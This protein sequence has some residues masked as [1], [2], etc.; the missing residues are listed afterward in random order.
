MV[1]WFGYFNMAL[2][3]NGCKLYI[4]AVQNG[5]MYI[6]ILLKDIYGRDRRPNLAI[7]VGWS[8]SIV[9]GWVVLGQSKIS[10]FCFRCESRGW[11]GGLSL[12]FSCMPPGW[13]DIP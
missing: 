4:M 11:E 3:I 9:G 12:R 5:S 6:N 7:F 1:E 2:Y 10:S 13:K 8:T